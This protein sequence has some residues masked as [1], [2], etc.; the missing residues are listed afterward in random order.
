MK[1]FISHSQRQ[2]LFIKELRKHLPD[3]IELWIDEKKLLIGEE[4]QNT[5]KKTIDEDIHFLV[6]IIDRNAVESNWV[7]QEFEWGIKKELK[8]S[9]PFVLPIVLEKDIWDSLEDNNIKKRLFLPCYE[10]SDEAIAVTAKNLINQLFAWTCKELYGSG[11]ESDQKSSLDLLDEADN[12]I[13]EIAE[14]VRLL[15]YP[16]R[17]NNPLDLLQLL[18]MLKEQN[19]L[20]DISIFT[21]KELIARI[22]KQNHL[23]GI[24]SDGEY[25]WVKQEHY[26]WKLAIHSKNKEK[27][28]KRAIK[29]IN[30]NYIIAL[31]S[32]STT[33]AIAKE[34]N[35]GLEMGLWDNLKVVTNS[36]PIAQELFMYSSKLGLVDNNNI[37]SVFM[38][39]GRIR[40][41]SLAVVNDDEIYQNVDSGFQETISKLGGAD[42]CFV[43]ANGVYRNEGFAVHSTYEIR[44][45]SEIL[46]NCKNK[47]IVIDSSKLK[48]QEQNKFVDFNDDIKVITTEDLTSND[49]VIIKKIAHSSSLELILV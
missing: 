47:F 13:K 39:E 31:D 34:I 33:L 38:T 23:T 18:D 6:L 29:F 24:V 35:K 3:F 22:I 44:S 40:P 49:L 14:K 12:F 46:K 17:Q 5:I 4:V 48:I 20:V 42:I 26:S 2:K 7:M 32:G 43:G 30:S 1:I 27:I 41:N 16:Y 19:E 8:L 25:I 9:R 10:F 11:L 45:K 21:F 36:I 15:V 28:A 37:L